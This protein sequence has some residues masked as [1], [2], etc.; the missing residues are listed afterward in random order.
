MK[1][2]KFSSSKKCLVQ[3]IFNLINSL[4][5]TTKRI[6]NFETIPVTKRQ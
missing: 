6:N 2:I 3:E 4:W 5:K 1:T